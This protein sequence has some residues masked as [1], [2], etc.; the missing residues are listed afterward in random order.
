MSEPITVKK[1]KKIEIRKERKV[2]EKKDSET[3]I[4]KE[5][6]QSNPQPLQVHN[7]LTIYYIL[8]KYNNFR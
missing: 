8:T 5:Q 4:L 6:K 7:I 2:E 3:E 1:E